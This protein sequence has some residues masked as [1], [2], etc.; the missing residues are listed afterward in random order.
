[1]DS[2]GLLVEGKK[3]F[4]ALA[5]FSTSQIMGYLKVAAITRV[6]YKLK[7]GIAINYLL[8]TLP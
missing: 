6:A 7:M 3:K 1:M 5:G 2:L 8:K 4:G